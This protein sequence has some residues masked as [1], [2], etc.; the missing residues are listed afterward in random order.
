MVSSTAVAC[1]ASAYW[2]NSTRPSR[3][4]SLRPLLRAR[5]PATW[6]SPASSPPATTVTVSSTAA[7]ATPTITAS[8]RWPAM[9]STSRRTAR[10]TPSS[11]MTNRNRMT[12]APA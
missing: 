9:G 7:R 11:M 6:C 10:S 2:L 3:S 12:M 1:T 4:T 8:G 5:S